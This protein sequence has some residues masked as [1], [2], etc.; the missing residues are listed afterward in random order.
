M[1][2]VRKAE[3]HARKHGAGMIPSSAKG[4]SAAMNRARQ[5]LWDLEVRR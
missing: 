5:E 2:E 3:A 4:M 1:A